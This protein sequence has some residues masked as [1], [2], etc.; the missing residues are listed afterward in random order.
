MNLFL[1]KL[2]EYIDYN[3]LHI[4]QLFYLFIKIIF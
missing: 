2:Y 4:N 1:M 3:E